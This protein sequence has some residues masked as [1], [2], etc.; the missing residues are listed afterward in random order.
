MRLLGYDLSVRGLSPRLETRSSLDIT[1]LK[2]PLEWLLRFSMGSAQSA[3]GIVVTPLKALGVATVFACVRILSTTISTLP[4]EVVQQQGRAKRKAT[5]HRLWRVLGKKPNRDMSST[6]WREAVQANLTLLASG[7]SEILRDSAGNAVGVYPIETSRMDVHRKYP[8]GST[9]PNPTVYRITDNNVTLKPEDVLHLKSTSFNGLIGINTTAAV[10]EVI[11]LALA[12]QDNAAKFFGNGSRPGGVLEHPLQ[13]SKE[14]QD[15]LK[16]QFEEQT[17]GKNLYRL[18]VLEEGLKYNA[19][20]SEN[21]DAQFVEA[22]DAQTLEICRI[23]GIP[24][25]KVGVTHGAPRA[26]VEEENIAFMTDVIRPLAY[27]W[28][29]EMDRKLFSDRE[30]ADGYGTY[31]NLDAMLRGN[32]KARYESYAVGRQW[33]ILSQNDCRVDDNLDEIDGGDTYLQPINMIDSTKA[34][35]LQMKQASAGAKQKNKQGGVGGK[36]DANT[37]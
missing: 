24:P 33:G 12:M 18:M 26:N 27:K 16:E 1:D 34:T 3:T 5:E 37:P 32:R 29:Q 19:T 21:R 35:E 7:Y 2:D 17:S 14:A 10:R 31:F 23:W 8:A 6:D 28:E 36:P 25:H 15:R 11:A 30:I 9:G 13:L 4:L 22:R 20:R